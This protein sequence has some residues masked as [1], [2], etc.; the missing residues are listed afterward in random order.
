MW[1]VK[2]G[3]IVSEHFNLS[4]TQGVELAEKH[5]TGKEFAELRRLCKKYGLATKVN[6]KRKA[7]E[8]DTELFQERVRKL[9]NA[10]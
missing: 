4:L 7:R 2:G 5:P 3:R 10:S 8:V 9:K 6:W 1:E